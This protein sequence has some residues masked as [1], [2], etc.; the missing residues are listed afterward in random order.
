[1]ATEIASIA[2]E[3]EI[4]LAKER[5]FLETRRTNNEPAEIFGPDRES[6]KKIAA[7]MAAGGVVAI[8]W[9]SVE[10]RIIILGTSHDNSESTQILNEIKGRPA[11]QVLAVG[12]LPETVHL[13]AR[14]EDSIPLANAAKK[15]FGVDQVN[16][17]LLTE[18]L[19]KLYDKNSLGLILKAKSHLPDAI[20]ASKDG[21]RTVMVMGASDYKDEFDVYN[22]VL[23]ELATRYG[24]AVAG[25]SA[26]ESGQVV[27]S[28]TEQ[29]D[30]YE[31]LKYKVDGFVMFDEV[32]EGSPDKDSVASSTAI[33][34]TGEH[35][36]VMR[37]GSQSPLRFK[38]FFPD[39]IV[40]ENVSRE[41]H[42]EIWEP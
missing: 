11:R 5:L 4:L 24:K 9:G 7:L 15:L 31:A 23:W 16:E 35:P 21:D 3:D 20:T 25:T 19:D 6:V 39:L 27:Y 36:V 8:P 18:T 40:P 37:W 22:W 34:L 1:M 41:E 28:V 17:K 14:V 12:C 10:R 42:A 30:A 33:D 26:N 2:E 13:V 32:P 38:E 29:K